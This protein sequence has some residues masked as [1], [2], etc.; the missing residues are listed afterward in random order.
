MSDPAAPPDDETLAALR[1]SEVMFRGLLEAPPD[2]M[3]I[4]DGGGRISLVNGQAEALLGYTRAELIGQ[5]VEV[6]VP[7]RLRRRHAVS[8]DRFRADPRTRP[9]GGGRELLAVCKDGSEVPVE[10]SLSQL[11]TDSGPLVSVAIRDVRERRL[12]EHRLAIS[13]R[14]ASI[15]TMVAGLAHEINNPLTAVLANVEFALQVVGDGAPGGPAASALSEATKALADARE[16]G[17]RLQ[18]IM[19]DLERFSR[20][21]S[22]ATRPVDPREAV[23]IAARQTSHETRPRG[24]V[25]LELG[26]T[27]WVEANLDGLVQVVT[28]LLVNAAHALEGDE[29]SA[30]QIRVVTRTD[31]RG[32]AVI[33]VTDTG[34]GIAPEDLGRV[35][36]PFFTSKP[37]G[38]GTGLGLAISQRIIGSVAG[39]LTVESELGRGSTFRVTLPPCTAPLPAQSPLPDATSTSSSR[40]PGRVLVIDDEGVVGRAIARLLGPHHEVTVEV[41]AR[42][43]P[44]LAL[45]LMPDLIL[46]DLMMPHL[47]GLEVYRAIAARSEALAQRI[48]FITGGVTSPT[49][50]AELARLGTTVVS[51]P[52]TGAE[53]RRLLDER[54]A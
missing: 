13:E 46:C 4:A 22:V 14:L 32:R 48:V 54:L 5:P 47:S 3:V 2:A 38:V 53:L 33:E 26:E 15:G 50:A 31:A 1:R 21:D 43:G 28:N 35:F 39:T 41:D 45:R 23:E 9:M 24:T 20:A 18:R 10:I 11:A 51:K 16:A 29:P 37:A 25:V 52:F 7:A 8:A 49:M 12:L 6:L 34:S 30:Q 19:G 44:D 17:R 42:R 36:D 40:R 27:P